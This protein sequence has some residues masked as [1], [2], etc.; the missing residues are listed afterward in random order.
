MIKIVR[1]L[2]ML[3]LPLIA[4]QIVFSQGSNAAAQSTVANPSGE[5]E[6]GTVTL[7]RNERKNFEKPKDSNES[8]SI[9]KSGTVIADPLIRVLVKKGILTEVEGNSI[10]ATGNAVERRD[11]LASLLRD[12]GLITS[13]EYEA[14]RTITP[15]DTLAS[16]PTAS[17][18]SIYEYFRASQGSCKLLSNNRSDG[19]RRRRTRASSRY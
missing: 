14:V 13:V 5:S 2:F 12:K 7:D 10:S 3:T 6:G 9:D 15:A 17:S 4:V 19:N 8:T 16:V 18:G 1:P 11:R